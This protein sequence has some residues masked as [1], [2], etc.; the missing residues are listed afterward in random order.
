[1]PE[2]VTVEERAEMTIDAMCESS[3]GTEVVVAARSHV[4]RTA[5]LDGCSGV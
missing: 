2:G 3:D 5:F 1:M 4:L